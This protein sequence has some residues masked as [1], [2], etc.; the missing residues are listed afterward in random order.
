MGWDAIDTRVTVNSSTQIQPYADADAGG[1]VYLVWT[2][3]R[4]GSSNPDI[5]FDSRLFGTWQGNTA[6]VWAATDTTNSVQRYPGIAHD[7]VGIAYVSWT[8]ERLPASTGKNREAFYKVGIDV[9]TAVP[10]SEAPSLSRLLRN[11]PNPF[12][13]QTRIQFALERDA[14]VTLR[15]FDVHG[16]A[17]RQLVDSYLSA[18]PR[19]V[20][21]D[22]K[23][24]RGLT[25]P[26]GAY[27][28]RLE[29]GGKYVTRTVNLVK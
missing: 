9:V 20:D 7:G 8:D 26:S 29:G 14:H 2:D 23:D 22:G 19:T 6:L 16:R 21:W 17:V 1:N 28:L 4:N 3:L 10:V 15:V 13:P 27:F 5:Y 24:Q 25:L 12:N 18:G 11:Y